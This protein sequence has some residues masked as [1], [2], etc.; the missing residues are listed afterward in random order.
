M[1]YMHNMV[2]INLNDLLVYINHD[3]LVYTNHD[4]R[5]VYTNHD[6]CF[7]VYEPYGVYA[8]Y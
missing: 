7:G 4:Y 2:Y 3:R 1:V 6:D 5:L 8:T